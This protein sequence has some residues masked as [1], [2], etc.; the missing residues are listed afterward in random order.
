MS[1]DFDFDF[2]TWTTC[3][4]HGHVFADEDGPRTTCADCGADNLGL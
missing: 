3:E 1:T 4:V 2:E